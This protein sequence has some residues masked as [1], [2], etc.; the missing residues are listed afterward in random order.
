[1]Y[2]LGS[3]KLSTTKTSHGTTELGWMTD[4]ELRLKFREGWMNV[5]GQLISIAP[6]QKWRSGQQKWRSGASQ[7]PF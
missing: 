7:N 2:C 6:Q 4:I 5:L 1:M 3:L